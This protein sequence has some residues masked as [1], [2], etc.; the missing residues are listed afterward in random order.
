MLH[1]NNQPQWSARDSIL[2]GSCL[3]FALTIAFLL[4]PTG[5]LAHS[6]L[7]LSSGPTFHVNAGFDARYRDGNWIPV[8][9]TLSN[10]G[11]DFTG[12][13]SVNAPPPYL[14]AGS[15]DPQAVYQAPISLANGAQKQVTLYVP[16][17]FGSQG[18]TQTFSVNLLNSNGQKVSSQMTTVRTLGSNDIFVG[19]LSDQSTGFGPL[20]TISLPNQAASL[21][22]EQLN[23]STMPTR[24][25]V[26]KNFDLIVLDN[27]TTSALSQDQL[28]ALQSW[29][30]QGGALIVVGGPEW[31]HTL[32]PLPSS[33]LPVAIT[34]TA[35][36]PAG[37]P[38]LPIGGPT[39]GGPGHSKT[40]DTVHTP[41]TVSTA[42]PLSGSSVVLTSST[43]PLIVQSHLG[44][45]T[46][47]YLAFDPTLEPIL[48][49]SSASILWKGL[50]LRTLGDQLV[51]PNPS[52]GFAGPVG[53]VSYKGSFGSL[54]QAFLPNTFPSITFIL[55]LLL[56]YILVL[57][58]VRF[59]IIRQLKRRD[60]SWRITLTTILVFSLLSYGL[61]LQ[62]K[63]TAI[64]SDTA[65]I[66]QLGR[67]GTAGTANSSAHITTYLGVFV[68][69]QGDFQ[70]H[71]DGNSLV[72]PSNSQI[73]Y[74][75]G[76]Q[77][78]QLTTI[79]ASPHG[80][81][82]NLQGVNIWTFH[83]IV[84]EKDRSVHGGIIPQLTLKD[85]MLTGTVTNTLPYALSDVYVL[86]SDNYT[87][88][89]SL[90]AEQTKRISL[91]VDASVNSPAPLLAEQIASRN[92]QDT[93]PYINA[94]QLHS[95]HQRHLA[96]LVA[97][98]GQYAGYY[99]GPGGPCFQPVPIVPI[100]KGASIGRSI[101]AVNGTNVGSSFVYS[102]TGAFL[103][104]GSPYILNRQ[105]PLL[106]PD[107]PATLIGWIDTSADV[108]NGITING[109]YSAG[110]Q[111][112]LVQ[113]PLDVNFAGSVNLGSTFVSS[114][115]VDVES[116]GN[117]IQEQLSGIYTMTTGSM[118][119]E[120]TL[121]NISTLHADS[122]T[123][124]EP[125]NIAAY[126]QKVGLPSGQSVDANHLHAF[127]YNWQ[128]G[129]WDSIVL[130]Q[131]SYS[132][133]NITPYIG[134]GGRILLQFANQ[135]S[136]QG[137]IIF[138]KPSLQ[139]QGTVA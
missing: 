50:L 42:T 97:L 121:P 11:A 104:G 26:L 27:F 79:T 131:F 70:V 118:T 76:P 24:A 67:P 61:A 60:W 52:P 10:N 134:S 41:V 12:A 47:C 94:S 139:L 137:T 46:T 56:G 39:K 98:S 115:V 126:V 84:A 128:A 133:N 81:D 53:F 116:Q 117:N 64:L 48:S 123:I 19:V 73:Q 59:L 122:A 7:S 22:V 80:T 45:G 125:P 13:I 9:I 113:A 89:G 30:N 33:L 23:A 35:D 37:T 66:M 93:G 29:V 38:L 132:T 99:C 90:P 58:P 77:T 127:L 65:S 1:R 21:L 100:Y 62:Q 17:Y 5:A 111:E 82:V 96:M 124:T 4:F 40:S 83:T 108:A 106:I 69:N 55:V 28:A 110:L 51:T 101:A 57:G 74:Y 71:M 20:S 130:N 103:S 36:I 6:T 44:Q 2:V 8:Q 31:R 107:A 129:S 54:L 75:P 78:P 88:L 92:G 86:I 119:F 95:E 15:S 102:S 63:G 120:F 18:S 85:G 114:Q 87:S 16:L 34:G 135:D 105:D 25:A 136:S 3:A 91:S 112:T 49:W 68:P 43:T 14:G 72:Q 138:G 32:S 109:N